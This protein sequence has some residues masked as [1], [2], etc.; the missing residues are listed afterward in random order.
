MP[1][2][3]TVT[4]FPPLGVLGGPVEP[5]VLSVGIDPINLSGHRNKDLLLIAEPFDASV[6]VSLG[7]YGPIGELLYPNGG[8]WGWTGG[9]SALYVAATT[10]RTSANDDTPAAQYVP[11]KLQPFNFGAHLYTSL[12]PVSRARAASGLAVLIDPEGRLNSLIGRVWDGTPITIK[13]GRRG[14]YFNTWE[15]VAKLRA[16]RLLYDVDSKQIDLRDLGWQLSGPI[17][18]E[19]YLGTG[20]VEGDA[21]AKG[22]FKPWALGYCFNVEPVLLSGTDQIF[23]F[24]LS[25]ATA[26]SALRHGGVALTFH[27]DYADY[28]ALAAATIPSSKYGTCLA[29]SLVR[30]NVTLQFSIRL[31]VTGD[32]DVTDGHPAPLTRASI[33]RRV[34]TSRG[35]NRTDDATEIDTTAFNTMEAYHSAPV[36]WYFNSQVSKADALDR[37]LGGVLGWWRVRPDGRLCV[38]WL[39]DPALIPPTVTFAYRSLGMGKPHVLEVIPPR[40]G[41]YVSYQWNNGPEQRA[42]LAGSVADADAA[43]YGQPAQYASSLTPAVASV[44]PTAPTVKVE[45]SGFRDMADAAVEAVR[46]HNIFPVERRRWE[47]PMEIDPFSDVVSV[48]FAMTGANELALGDS[49]ASICIGIDSGGGAAPVLEFFG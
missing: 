46:Q 42:Q 40:V 35:A 25:S 43:I 3:Q 32:A 21:S 29:Q 17:H 33:A 24:S 34:A 5:W 7:L 41:T 6:G 48:G 38:G 13:R 27:A 4:W 39:Q 10:G 26:V 1:Q 44:Y 14:T 28:A 15:T 31:D 11:G 2:L 20:G 49:F 45:D 12:N 47:W 36:G 37:I 16:A 22:K 18:D 8:S 30:P 19:F 9:R 23:Q